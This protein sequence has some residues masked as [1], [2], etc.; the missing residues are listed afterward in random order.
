M[1]VHIL[2]TTYQNNCLQKSGLSVKDCLFIIPLEA[3]IISAVV[4][5]RRICTASCRA[6]QTVIRV[7]IGAGLPAM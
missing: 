2:L 5:M 4:V 1:I 3:N 6:G 7:L